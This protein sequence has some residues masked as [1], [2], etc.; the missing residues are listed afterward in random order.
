MRR[1]QAKIY[2]TRDSDNMKVTAQNVS[3]EF[4]P[5]A[6][7][8]Q[9]F[10]FECLGAYST[11]PTIDVNLKHQG[12][13]VL[14][15]LTVPIGLN[16]FLTPLP[17]PLTQAAFGAKWGALNNPT[18]EASETIDYEVDFTRESLAAA[19][20]AYKLPETAGAPL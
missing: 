14:L 6:Q 3:P 4:G 7:V 11:L 17:A 20:S 1:S 9:M 10:N 2:M 13:P 12:A 18:M 8:P 19:L 5:K 16:K 15:R